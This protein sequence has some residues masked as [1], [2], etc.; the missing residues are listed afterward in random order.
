M[1]LTQ[2]LK[3][4]AFTYFF[5]HAHSSMILSAQKARLS[6]MQNLSGEAFILRTIS[7]SEADLIVHALS[8]EH[9]LLHF[10][11][12]GAKK[13]KKR[14]SG[15]VLQAPHLISFDTGR[16]GQKQHE[17]G[18][19][20][21]LK[22]ASLLNDFIKIRESYNS[23]ETM[24]AM[25]KVVLASETGHGELFNHFGGA[26]K[27]L[28]GVKDHRR[29]FSH[30]VVRYLYIEG[31]LPS[32]NDFLEFIQ[33]PLSYHDRLKEVT[34]Q[35]VNREVGLAA[36]FLKTYSSAKENIKWPS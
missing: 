33:T 11:V 8:K 12:R 3:K 7:Y 25:I 34:E 4:G 27:V 35:Q 6:L 29:F 21:T 30:F 18:S 24:F 14:F 10:F 19:L 5:D 9:G 22:E 32:Q 17:E 16:T 13:S 28:P 1:G 26:L 36:H 20:I 23:I 31:V 15:G 2:E